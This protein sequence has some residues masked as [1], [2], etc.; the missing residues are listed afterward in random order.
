MKIL[1]ISFIAFI[2]WSALSTY[3]YVCKIKGLCDNELSVALN[4]VELSQPAAL[5]T[6]TDTIPAKLMPEG[7]AIAPEKLIVYFDFNNSLFQ[8][9]KET[10]KFYSET[11]VY[12]DQNPN[13]RLHI[14]GHTCDIGTNKYN[15][16]LGSRR[17]KSVFN[18]FLINGIPDNKILTN[19]RGESEPAENNNTASGRAK[20]RRAE[21]TIK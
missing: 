10:E 9:D 21:I 5:E 1:L 8:D 4:E 17:A 20:N 2:S 7:S 12:L 19:S 6:L 11:R 14:T 16:D 15:Q 18:Y 13:A 3:I